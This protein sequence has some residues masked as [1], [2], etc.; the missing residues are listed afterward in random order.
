MP[1]A[2]LKPPPGLSG[3]PAGLNERP[4]LHPEDRLAHLVDYC[5]VRVT[6]PVAVVVP[7]T[8]VTV[9]V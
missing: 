9:I 8:S 1:G 7:D 3:P 6:V 4:L 5:T 2:P